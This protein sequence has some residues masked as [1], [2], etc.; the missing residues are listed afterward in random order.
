[1]IAGKDY[2]G[3]QV[4][5]WSCGVI[6]YAMLCGYLPFEDP[7]TDKLYKKILDC[8]YSIPN[9]VSES[10][11]NLIQKILNTNPEERY[12]IQ[13]IRSHPWFIKNFDK[14]KKSEPDSPSL[15]ALDIFSQKTQISDHISTNTILQNTKN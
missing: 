3:L 12:T 7:N 8:D 2:K 1:M 14:S 10:G 11:R 13:Q 9:Y 4:D 5:I 15:Q 6:L